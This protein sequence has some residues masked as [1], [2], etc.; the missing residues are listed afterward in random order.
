[1]KIVRLSKTAFEAT[2][3]TW[4]NTV[5]IVNDTANYGD[6]NLEQ[7]TAIKENA[8]RSLKVEVINDLTPGEVKTRLSKYPKTLPVIMLG[9]LYQNKVQECSYRS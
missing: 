5:L 1:M 6:S 9:Q 3:Q 7:I 4:T 2:R 8:E